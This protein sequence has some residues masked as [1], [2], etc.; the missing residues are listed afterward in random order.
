MQYK[1][2]SKNKKPIRLVHTKGRDELCIYI[3][4]R[5]LIDLQYKYTIYFLIDKIF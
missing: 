2:F 3:V 5:G 1:H 4:D